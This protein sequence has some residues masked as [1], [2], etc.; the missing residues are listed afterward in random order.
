MTA[1]RLPNGERTYSQGRV[2]GTD[3]HVPA[4]RID[5]EARAA[6]AAGKSLLDACPY[7]F[8]SDAGLHFKAVFLHAGG[9]A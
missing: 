8:A 4:S 5:A 6:A 3:Q 2:F 7:P 9:K 1:P